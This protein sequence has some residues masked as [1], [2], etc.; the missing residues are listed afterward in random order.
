MN[1]RDIFYDT[2]KLSRHEQEVVLR[3]AH[4][5]CERW[6]FDKLDCLESFAR[7]QVKGISF[8][9][10]M[11]HFVEGALM[12]VIH[13]RQILPLE[14]PDGEPMGYSSDYKFLMPLLF[15]QQYAENKKL[16]LLVREISCKYKKISL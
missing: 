11:G 7:Q 15:F 12:N 8:E 3:K 13:R 10:A 9:D 1:D 16:A 14:K 2:A 5:I 6:W 4:S